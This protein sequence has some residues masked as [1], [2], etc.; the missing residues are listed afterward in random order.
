[1]RSL[2]LF[3]LVLLVPFSLAAQDVWP[4]DVNDN[5]TVNGVD[6]LYWGIAYGAEG[7]A[8]SDTNSE[9]S[10]QPLP[11]LWT[12]SF[13]G[14]LNYAY[15]D[16]NGDGVVDEEDFDDAIDENFG[17][18]NPP[19][20]ADQYANASGG[21]APKLRLIPSAT[22]VEE[23]AI[24]DITLSLDL[25]QGSIESFYG[26]ALQLSYTTG[27][28]EDDD[29]PEFDLEEDSW[30]EADDSFVQELYEDEDGMGTAQFAVTRTNQ[31]SVAAEEGVIGR[32]QI[33]VEDIIVGLEVDTF[34]IRV[35]SVL[36]TN[37]QLAAVP[38]ITDSAVVV[39]AKDTSLLTSANELEKPAG[40]IVQCYPNP[41]SDVLF[42]QLSTPSSRLRMVGVDGRIWYEEHN[43]P[44]LNREVKVDRLPPG[45]YWLQCW[46]TNGMVSRRIIVYDP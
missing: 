6:L 32:F 36:I 20:S 27:L 1:M 29:G 35:D 30:L 37:S 43:L 44:G 18:E 38:V 31:Q 19:I 4:G 25:S 41:V 28:L 15:A 3:A 13:P 8:R 16:C 7:P 17:L 22:L 11:E 39:I 14:G 9:W 21:N 26:M 34:I 5:G 12:Q 46:T 24:V 45:L 23:G 40:E 33:I 42:I 10:A 2:V